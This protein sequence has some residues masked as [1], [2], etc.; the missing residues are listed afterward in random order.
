MEYKRQNYLCNKCGLCKPDHPHINGRGNFNAPLLVLG[1]SPN[2]AEMEAQTTFIGATGQLLDQYLKHYGIEY[3]IDNAIRTRPTDSK[4]EN[5]PPSNL[6]KDCCRAFTYELIDTMKPKVILVLGKVALNQLIKLAINTEYI[7]GKKI[8]VPELNCYIVMTYHPAYLMRQNNK[9]LYQQF[10]SDIQLA[11]ELI[12]SFSNRRINTV[13]RTLSDPCEIRD[14]LTKL[15]TVPAF[16]FDLETTGVD[17]RK[18]KITDISFCCEAGKGI[19]IKWSNLLEHNDLF[20]QVLVADNEM[21]IHNL[22]FERNFLYQLGYKF[23]SKL[24]DTMLAIHT[25]SMSFEGKAANALVGLDVASWYLSTEGG[26]K[27]I[28]AKYGGIK[29][30][31]DSIYDE[32]DN[33]DSIMEKEVQG[34]LFNTAEYTIEKEET[35]LKTDYD[36]YLYRYKNFI[37]N[38]KQAKLEELKLN[39]LQFYSAM[40]SDV[41]FRIYKRLK[42]E[43][44]KTFAYP[45]YEIIMPLCQVL[46]QIT[47]NGIKLDFH[48]M[49]KVKKLN[50]IDIL[51]LQKKIHKKVGYVFNIDSPDEVADLMYNKLGLKPDKNFLTKKGKKPAAD[52]K[53]ITFFSESKPI[54]KEIL[55][56]RTLKKQNS[57]Y[58][59][60][61]K[62]KADPQTHRIY[63]NYFQLTATGRSSCFLHTVPKDNKIRNMITVDK[64]RKLLVLD[65]SQVELRML[66]MLSG[67]LNMQKAFA[68]GHDF[69]TYTGCEM[70]HIDINKFDKKNN[71]EHAKARDRAKIINFGM[72]FLKQAFSLAKDLNIS[73][74]EAQ[75]FMDKFFNSYPY[76]KKY[77]NDTISFTRQHG[78]IETLYGR[79]RY[80]P[81]INSLDDKERSE[82]ERMAVNSSI[83]S[84]SADITAFALQKISSYIEKYHKDAFLVGTVHDSI[85]ID[86][87][88]EQVYDVSQ[89]AIECMTKDIPRITIPLKVDM[90]ILDHWEK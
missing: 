62:D 17:H 31:Q 54:L 63:P 52:A 14:Y 45:F 71:P 57:T 67:D 37:I 76:V 72:V 64:G 35:E 86:T 4:G 19:H 13:P 77:I 68:S 83:Q 78:Y 1:E 46:S 53:A 22:S 38:K 80:L 51:A 5:R 65:E 49:D 56:Y 48:H 43:I 87:K 30:Y 32:E 15:I 58:L 34:E 9:L 89:N 3:Y 84:P 41:T 11:G 88:E 82:A 7:R 39:P 44:D 16:A 25:T 18:D 74:A 42:V 24:F 12:K 20:K 26:Y 59:V 70:F 50:D 2:R 69:H 28:L 75:S 40:D 73:E 60:G 27:G 61:F 8:Y 55:E 23:N 33:D 29:G 85:L 90:D 66:S 47:L 36:R 10:E 81:K 6:E 21:C 79:R